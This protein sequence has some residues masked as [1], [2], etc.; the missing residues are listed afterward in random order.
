VTG[1]SYVGQ[2]RKTP[3]DR[4]IDC[5]QDAFN[6]LTLGRFQR[7]A[8]KTLYEAI[9]MHGAAE[10]DHTIL[11]EHDDLRAALEAEQR[12][13]RNHQTMAPD[14]YNCSPGGELPGRMRIDQV[15]AMLGVS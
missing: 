2:T 5:V 8:D 3:G 10:W 11:E 1:K 9:V 14:G 12:L 4:W 7:L 13:I 15:K 6:K